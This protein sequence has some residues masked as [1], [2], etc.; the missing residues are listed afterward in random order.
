MLPRIIIRYDDLYDISC[1]ICKEGGRQQTDHI[2]S[3]YMY[4][5]YYVIAVDQLY[6]STA[7]SCAFP[8]S[9]SSGCGSVA[10]LAPGLIIRCTNTLKRLASY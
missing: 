7:S 1:I 8:A 4:V 9:C 6:I 5:I 2:M 3:M 10:A